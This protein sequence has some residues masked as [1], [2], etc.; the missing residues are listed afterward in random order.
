[1]SRKLVYDIFC[2]LQ[3]TNFFTSTFSVV[4]PLM[5]FSSAFIPPFD[6][7][8]HW[9]IFS[10]FTKHTVWCSPS[11]IHRC[12]MYLQLKKE[13]DYFIVIL[14][15]KEPSDVSFVFLH[16]PVKFLISLV[17]LFSKSF[18]I[19]MRFKFDSLDSYIHSLLG[20]TEFKKTQSQ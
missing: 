15:M 4:I 3:T 17:L 18:L 10:S 8:I 7:S 1:M 2:A 13:R 14:I 9:E 11:K 5:I 6:L 16:W 20:R 12:K 19:K